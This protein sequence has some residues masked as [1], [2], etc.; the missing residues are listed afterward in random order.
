MTGI[1]RRGSAAIMLAL[2]LPAMVGLVDV[3]L[4]LARRCADAVRTQRSL[5]LA[6]I[7]GGLA[8]AAGNTP[9]GA[10]SQAGAVARLNGLAD[11]EVSIE[12]G[13]VSGTDSV[14]HVSAKGRSAEAE[15]F[16][17][18]TVGLVQ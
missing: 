3:S 18:R 9:T 14:V 6:A 5:D 10:A 13:I 15:L 12:P 2:T 4:T 16:S 8:L 17:A 11:A 7:A 1:G